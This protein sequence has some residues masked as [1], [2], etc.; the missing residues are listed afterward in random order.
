MGKIE[1]FLGPMFSGKTKAMINRIKELESQGKKIKVFKPAKDNRY[2]ED[3]LCTHDKI[4]LKAHNIKDI[5][6][7]EVKDIDVIAIDEFHF[8]NSNLID[9]CKK[10]KEEGKHVLVT[11]LDL[12]Y[13][14]YSMKFVDSNKSSD[15]LKNIANKINLLK[16]KCAVCNE[17]ATMTERISKSDCQHL[18]GGA[19][20]YRPVCKKHHPKWKK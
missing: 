14:G 15:D 11:G 20:A 13:L 4:S 16:S 8:F 19:E 6:E 17:E 10:W 7:A 1:I 9:S 12:N 3:F 18:V 2:S 5:E